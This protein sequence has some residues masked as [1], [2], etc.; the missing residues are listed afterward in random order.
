MSAQEQRQ[1][2]GTLTDA[3]LVSL[4]GNLR[5]FPLV[6]HTGRSVTGA[7]FLS[8]CDLWVYEFGVKE[9]LNLQ[10]CY[11]GRGSTSTILYWP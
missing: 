6:D 1:L 9:I 8:K 11:L 4:A 5:T 7:L 10:S 2:L 3:A